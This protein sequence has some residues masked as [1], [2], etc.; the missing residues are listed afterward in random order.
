MRFFT[1]EEELFY[2]RWGWLVQLYYT[3][4]WD[5]G[6]E[7]WHDSQAVDEIAY[8][9][10]IMNARAPE[11]FVIRGNVFYFERLK[12]V[13][14]FRMMFE[15]HIKTIKQSKNALMRKWRV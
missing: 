10:E 14:E 12:D 9:R 2:K 4:S 3:Y 5:N 6:R 11:H 7:N 1:T 13:F 15:H 8:M